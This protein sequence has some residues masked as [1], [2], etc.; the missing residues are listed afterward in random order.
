MNIVDFNDF[1]AA[2][3]FLKEMKMGVVVRRPEGSGFQWS[4]EGTPLD[5]RQQQLFQKQRGDDAVWTDAETGLMWIFDKARCPV[6]FMSWNNDNY[7]A[8]YNDWRRPT[9]ADLKTLRGATKNERG[10]YV[11]E[12]VPAKLTGPYSCSTPVRRGFRDDGTTWNF[13]TNKFSEVDYRE[14][15]IQWSAQGEYAGFEKDRVS[16][17]GADIYVRGTRSDTLSEWFESQIHWAEENQYHNFP[18]TMDTILSLESLELG[19]DQFPPHLSKLQ[20]LRTVWLR[21]CTTLPPELCLLKNLEELKWGSLYYGS[22]EPCVM[23]E[24]IGGLSSL[25]SLKLENINLTALPSCIGELKSL[26]NL[27]LQH[28][29]VSVLP[30]SVGQLVSLEELILAHNGLKTLPATVRNLTSLLHLTINDRSLSKFPDF[31]GNLTRL[32]NLVLNWTNLGEMPEDIG[33]LKNLRK[34]SLKQ[35]GLHRL[36]TSISEIATL[37]SIDVSFNKIDALPLD[38]G[39]LCELESLSIAA[40]LV[41][42]LPNSLKKIRKLRHINISAT[43]LKFLPDWI[44]EMSSLTN[45]VAAKLWYIKKVPQYEGKTVHTYLGVLENSSEKEWLESLGWPGNK[46]EIQ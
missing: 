33:N 35:C 10:A 31:L 28:T 14:G 22:R 34:L 41:D 32:E 46:K 36:P 21:S 3:F 39:N 19:K 2:L 5:E 24:E 38:I 43:P 18:V 20:S 13:T 4:S 15:K 11:K 1:T 37:E 27:H 8:G 30:D 9:V 40:T 12:A 44:G 6:G 26:K 29:N 16:G 17:K 7:F 23:T 45:I 25:I 42:E